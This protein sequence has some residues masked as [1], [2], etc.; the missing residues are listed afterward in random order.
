M[1]AVET[2]VEIRGVTKV[3][4]RGRE[5]IEVLHGIDLDIPSGTSWP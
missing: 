2:L 5:R 4:R 3:Y 1:S